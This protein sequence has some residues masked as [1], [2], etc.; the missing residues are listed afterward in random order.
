MIMSGQLKVVKT[1]TIS[2]WLPK[3]FVALIIAVVTASIGFGIHQHRARLELAEKWLET[4]ALRGKA[5]DQET[6][7]HALIDKIEILDQEMNRLRQYE[8]N[9]AQL[10]QQYSANLDLATSDPVAITNKL[11][12][13]TSWAGPA[14]SLNGL[15]GSESSGLDSLRALGAG[16]AAIAQMQLDLDRLLMETE[17][18]LE[19]FD[20]LE[21][22]INHTSSILSATPY[23]LPLS[24][25]RLSSGFGYRKSPFGGG[26]SELHR[27]L[28]FPAPVGTP[29][30]APANGRVLS[31]ER[32]SGYGLLLT[33]NH[34]YGLVT[35]YAHLSECQLKEG[36]TVQRGQKIAKVGNTGRST[37]A[38]LHYE[39][40]LGGRH[41]DPFNFTLGKL[42]SK[43]ADLKEDLKEEE[44][45][46]LD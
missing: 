17:Q 40:I 41:V 30:Y 44:E 42:A 4:E 18:S 14:Y 16:E 45:I 33:I 39:T 29:I 8:T 34:G 46:P 1:L 25:R 27:G 15:G 36:E 5:A 26:V 19:L 13:L 28:D 38:H 6:K 21:A 10:A 7:I 12:R 43:N 23:R 22:G 35:R 3:A 32:S 11:D 20:C 24:N 9:L 31:V 37:G 2:S